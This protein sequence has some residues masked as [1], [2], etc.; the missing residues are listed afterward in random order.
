MRISEYYGL[1]RTQPTLDFV[2]VDI[3][4]DT[5]VFI[6]PHGLRLLTNPWSQECVATIQNFFQ[7]VLD[8]I[9]EGNNDVAKSLLSV[10]REPNETHLGL[11]I[12]RAN[13]K[14][15]GDTTSV[16]V[17][18]AL[19][20]SEAVKSGLLEDLED[21]IL[22]IDGISSDIISD[23]TTNIIRGPLIH[24][25]QDM[26]SYYGIPL[27][28][29]V[30]SG[31][32]WNPHTKRWIR[33]Y[34]RLPIAENN[35]LL[36]VPK[37]IVRRRM[38]YDVDEYYRHYLL[39][40]LKGIELN[41]NSGLVQLLKN[42]N[43]RVNI[44]DLKEKYGTGKAAIVRET[45]NHP[46]ILDRYREVKRNSFRPP[47]DHYDLSDMEGTPSPDWEALL[48]NVLMINTGVHESHDYEK[49]IESFFTAIFYPSLTN[50]VTQT[51]IHE[52]RKRIDITYS[53]MAQR[54]F[55]YWLALNF[56]S[57]NIFVECKNYSGEVGNPQLDQLSGRF[58][59]SRGQV[60]ILVCRSFD[61]K[62]LF[63]TRCKDTANDQRGFILVLDDAD[64]RSLI[65]E[66][67][68]KEAQDFLILSQQ[69]HNLIMD[70][71]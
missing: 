46:E 42:G 63:L 5:R 38:E 45:K 62:E 54:G 47:L 52:G 50:P 15:L 66:K 53:N 65:N 56:S 22:M 36:L 23:M 59:P 20:R 7:T 64:L 34:E 70:R 12:G 17:W 40:Y 13:G 60:G 27:V 2:D 39:E 69:F 48:N 24:Y 30:D 55:F 4:G 67:L 57:A 28:D 16:Y 3:W 10:L 1:N 43:K 71:N 25:T 33:N 37:A 11:S 29:E 8:A 6:D 18:E 49:A 26:A 61:N 58:S 51:E 68:T 32:I 35:K 41:A 44:K 21:T 9:H 31:L 14:A 19:S